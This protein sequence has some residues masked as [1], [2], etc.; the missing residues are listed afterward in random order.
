MVENTW[1][2]NV[3]LFVID[4]QGN[5]EKEWRKVKVKGHVDDII[6]YLLG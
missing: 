1:G 2:L 6:T 3:Q 4:S 5:I